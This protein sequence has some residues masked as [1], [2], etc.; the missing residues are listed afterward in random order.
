MSGCMK[1][2]TQQGRASSKYYKIRGFGLCAQEMPSLNSGRYLQAL[3]SWDVEGKSGPLIIVHSS[4]LLHN[5]SITIEAH[6]WMWDGW[7]PSA[8]ASCWYHAGGSFLACMICSEGPEHQ[9]P[10]KETN[11]RGQTEPSRRFSQKTK[12]WG[13]ASFHRKSQKNAG[14]RRKGVCPLRFV[15]FSEHSEDM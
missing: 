10:L 2:L 7:R 13:N 12:H 9:G 8:P 4:E 15:T 3:S 14:T 5:E 11:L 1:A 6:G